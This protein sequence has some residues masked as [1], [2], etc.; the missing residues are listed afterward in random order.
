MRFPHTRFQGPFRMI[1]LLF[2]YYQSY[3]N[4]QYHNSR[5]HSHHDYCVVVLLDRLF[6]GRLGC[7]CFRSCFRGFRCRRCFLTGR[8]FIGDH[9]IFRIGYH[10]PYILP[11]FYRQV[12]GLNRTLVGIDDDGVNPPGYLNS[13]PVP[14]LGQGLAGPGGESVGAVRCRPC[15]TAGSGPIFRQLGVNGD[16]LC[17]LHRSGPRK[18]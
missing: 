14:I 3:H 18:L 9:R 4:A 10:N 15:P 17:R 13:V 7:G 8:F 5:Y 16:V 1:L 2:L 6:R 11:H 12:G